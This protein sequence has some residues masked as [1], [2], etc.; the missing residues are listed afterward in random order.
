MV[1]KGLRTVPAEPIRRALESWIEERAKFNE[2]KSNWTT[3]HEFTG[4]QQAVWAIFKED[5]IQSATRNS[6]GDRIIYR[7]LD[8]REGRKP[9]RIVKKIEAYQGRGKQVRYREVEVEVP[10]EPHRQES[11]TFDLADKILTGL[12]MQHLWHE[13]PILAEAYL[14]LD[15]SAIDL[16]NPTSEKTQQEADE[17][18]WQTYLETGSISAT[19]KTLGV[20]HVFIKTK[21]QELRE[22]MVS[23]AA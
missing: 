9:G 3:G 15:M 10:G 6:N 17:I 13:D 20:S 14:K 1:Q 23:E 7:L 22:R 11:V 19:R 21:I 2:C 16:S 12:E 18:I 5:R 4:H 8:R